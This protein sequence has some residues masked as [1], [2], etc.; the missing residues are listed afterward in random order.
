[1]QRRTLRMPGVLVVAAVASVVAMVAWSV[2][3]SSTSAPLRVHSAKATMKSATSA[4]TIA[5]AVADSADPF[6]LTMECGAKAASKVYNV[7][8]TWQGSPS[9]DVAPEVATLEAVELRKPNGIIL[10]PFSPTVFIAPVKALMAKGI[11][12]VTVDGS[13]AQKVE[14]ENVR[15][16]N[17]AAGALAADYLAKRLKGTGIVGV[18]DST[19]SIPVDVDR[20]NGFRDEMKAKYPH[21]RVLGTQYAESDAGKAATITSALLE[22]HPNLS[23]LYVSDA[24]DAQ[25][26]A[27]AVVAAGDLGK[28]PVVGYDATPVEV[29]DL[30]DGVFT[31]LIAQ[32]PYQEGYRAVTVLARYI[33][34]QLT[35]AQIPYLYGTG[36][37][38]VTKANVNTPGMKK[39]LYTTTC[40]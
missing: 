32:E 40:G 16:N 3:A 28:V 24:G 1:M 29:T 22:A 13:L 15:T 11:P 17:T 6:Y 39:V 18:V 10:A 19:P 9:I 4:I 8:L 20:V 30:E 12:V 27:A 33:R 7:D 37:V 2:P 36:A 5:A 31:A 34:H 23:G 26:A 25:G 14:L 21:I 35:A 38:V